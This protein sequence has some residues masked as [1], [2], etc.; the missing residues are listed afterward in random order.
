VATV[1]QGRTPPDSAA[2]AAG[3]ELR[4]AGVTVVLV[5]APAGADQRALLAW[6]RR[7]TGATGLRVDDVWLFRLAP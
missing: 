6:T 2:R 3:R 7:A 5:A 1:A 4:A